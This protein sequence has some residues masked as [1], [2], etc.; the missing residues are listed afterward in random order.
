MSSMFWKE[1]SWYWL[2]DVEFCWIPVQVTKVTRDTILFTTSF[3]SNIQRNA[4]L[5]SLRDLKREII[6]PIAD[7]SIES[8]EDM[9]NV[10]DMHESAL[11]HNLELRYR[12]NHIYTS[13]GSILCAVNPYKLIEGLY[14]DEA[15][16]NYKGHKLGDKPPHVYALA[17]EA[18]SALWRMNKNQCILISGESGAGKTE[19]TKF[20]L[21][22][23]TVMSHEAGGGGNSTKVEVSYSVFY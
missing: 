20:I 12:S 23:L 7:S 9:S 4:L 3:K 22:F 6:Y 17:N 21:N 10:T 11:L 8:V 14:G 19:S 5:Y 1:G 13:I 2:K 15:I 16:S 18:Y